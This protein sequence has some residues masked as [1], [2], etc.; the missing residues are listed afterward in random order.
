MAR[1]SSTV[2]IVHTPDGPRKLGNNRPPGNRLK[3]IWRTLADVPECPEID[4]AQWDE[5]ITAIGDGPES[6]FDPRQTDQDGVGQCNANA[7]ISAMEA[8]RKQQGL[9]EILL[10]PADLYD[11]INGGGDN[12][13]ML[14][15]GIAEATERGVGTEATS[16]SV[17]KRGNKQA[18]A[19]ERNRFRVLEAVLCPTFSSLISATFYGFKIVSGVIWYGNYDPDEEGWLPAGRSQ[20]GGHAIYGFKPAKRDGKY[21]IWHK[22]SWGGNWGRGGFFVLPEASYKGPVGGWWAVREVTDEGG[23]VPLPKQLAERSWPVLSG[24]ELCHVV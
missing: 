20:V 16:G 12:G 21:G 22:N 4:R 24:V 9:S 10:S 14:E 11:R 1:R 3:S 8:A 7:T 15:D 6:P 17:W 19:A 13:S 23:V 5:L 18:G 2:P